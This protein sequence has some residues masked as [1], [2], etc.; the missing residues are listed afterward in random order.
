M[1]LS[2]RIRP[3]SEAADWVVEE[4]GKL[5]A[6]YEALKAELSLVS[7]QRN[8][9]NREIERLRDELA[10]ITKRMEW[11]AERA[12]KL[13][14][15]LEDTRR[16]L[17]EH[18]E[19]P[20]DMTIVYLSGRHDGKKDAEVRNEWR[21]ALENEA[22]VCHILSGENKGDPRKM[23]NDII[24]WHINVAVDPK[25]NGGYTLVKFGEAE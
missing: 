5:E 14:V 15:A 10:L 12:A 11:E 25:V 22:V 8:S 9:S 23:L 6:S 4:I 17:A 21:R 13:E 20:V 2:E 16:T 1:S 3:G 19:D 24:N 18:Q 7:G